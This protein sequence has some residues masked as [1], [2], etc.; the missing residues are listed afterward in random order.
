MRKHARRFVDRAYLSGAWKPP[1]GV[2]QREWYRHDVGWPAARYQNLFQEMNAWKLAVESDFTSRRSAV[3]EVFGTDV[4]KVDREIA[5]DKARKA[6]LEAGQP[7]GDIILEE[8]AKDELE[9]DEAFALSDDDAAGLRKPL[10][11]SSRAE[12]R[13]LKR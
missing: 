6:A 7:A 1:T 11:L 4:R 12:R 13:T 9:V 2:P 3:S 5:Q 10:K 8:V